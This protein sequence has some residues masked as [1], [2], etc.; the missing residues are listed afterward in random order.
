MEGGRNKTNSGLEMPLQ[1]KM[2][3]FLLRTHFT[4]SH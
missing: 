1:E 3:F 2:L 4:A